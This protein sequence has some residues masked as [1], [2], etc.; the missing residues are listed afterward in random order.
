[1]LFVKTA[2]LPDKKQNKESKLFTG[3]YVVEDI[4]CLNKLNKQTRMQSSRIRTA[5]SL[6]ISGGGCPVGGWCLPRGGGCLP[7]EG[8]P[9]WGGVCP[10]GV[11]C[12]L[13]HHA[14]DVTSMLFCHQLR[15]ITSAAAYILFSHVTWGTCWDTTTPRGQNNRHV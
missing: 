6:I 3:Q 7:R 8:V 2:V 13:S 9:V 4:Y 14:F 12:D 15:L 5:R 1:M 10:G 11:P